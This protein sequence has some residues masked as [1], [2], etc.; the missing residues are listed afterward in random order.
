[1]GKRRQS[2][3][4][5]DICQDGP[6]VKISDQM[7]ISG[8]AEQTIRN[9]IK[10]GDLKAAKRK[11]ALSNSTYFITRRN[12]RKWLIQLGYEISNGHSE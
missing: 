3:S 7:T 4:L 12:A 9:D 1:M 5:A 10:S 2:I 11:T 6:H 8:L